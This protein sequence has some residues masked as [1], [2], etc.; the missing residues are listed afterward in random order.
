M[1]QYRLQSLGA[2]LNGTN[3][4]V[5]IDRFPQTVALFN[6]HYQ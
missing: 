1:R 5:A 6:V 4:L 3:N 2:S